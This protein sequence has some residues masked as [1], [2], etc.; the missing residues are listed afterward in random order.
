MTTTG[1]IDDGGV[2]PGTTGT[3]IRGKARPALIESTEDVDLPPRMMT[4]RTGRRR[5]NS[6]TSNLWKIIKDRPEK[7]RRTRILLGIDPNERQ[8]GDLDP[9]TAR[10]AEGRRLASDRG[11]RAARTS[12]TP[13]RG[14]P[15]KTGSARKRPTARRRPRPSSSRI[16]LALPCPRP[17]LR[18]SDGRRRPPGSLLHLRTLTLRYGPTVLTVHNGRSRRSLL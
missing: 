16:D 5:P 18:R 6:P 8:I 1:V 9:K 11:P 14:R 3:T 15:I 4:T 17:V 2:G 13:K 7:R 12:S 10:G